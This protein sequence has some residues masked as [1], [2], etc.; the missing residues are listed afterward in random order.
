MSCLFIMLELVVGSWVDDQRCGAGKYSY[1]NGDY[2]DGEWQNH[3]RHG[4]GT[5]VYAETGKHTPQEYAEIF[6]TTHLNFAFLNTDY[7]R[8]LS[9][10]E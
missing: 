4:Q 10:I 3:V 1:V 7:I 6:S 2:Y 5:Y 9:D 8:W